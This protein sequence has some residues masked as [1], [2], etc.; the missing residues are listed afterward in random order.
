MQKNSGRPTSYV[1]AQPFCV[2]LAGAR[3]AQ[4][5]EPLKEV[6]TAR[7]ALVFGFASPQCS[8]AVPLASHPGG[9]EAQEGENV[10]GEGF[11]TEYE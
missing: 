1:C 4:V 8:G 10:L 2:S 7:F 3:A 11:H 6:G 9:P 5:A